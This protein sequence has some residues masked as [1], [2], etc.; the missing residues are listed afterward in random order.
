MWVIEAKSERNRIDEALD[1]AENYYAKRLNQSQNFKVLFISGLAGN[2]A[3]GYMITNKFLEQGVF[4]SITLN[5]KEMTGLISP[6]IAKRVLETG[7]SDLKDVPVDQA[8]FRQKADRINEILHI[9]A[10]NI[11]DRARV[12]AALLLSTLQGDL[13]DLNAAPAVLISDI[14]TRAEIALTSQGK[15]EFYEYVRLSLPTSLDN[16]QKYKKA[17]VETL[18]ELYGLNIR[19]AM[20]S[21]SDVLGQ[22]YEIFLKY[23]NWAQ[24]MGIVLTPRHITR[25]AAEALDVN[26]QDVVLDPCCGTG[27]FLVAAFDY[28]KALANPSQIERFKRAMSLG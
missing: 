4:K 13:A 2:D 3:D 21:G 14:N 19:S 12:M 6:E 26:L 24:K 22:F 10:V 9:G 11:N 18:K 7:C 16:H 28:V 1:E 5:D 8:Y 27:G 25:F 15:K 23:G 20:N 17:L